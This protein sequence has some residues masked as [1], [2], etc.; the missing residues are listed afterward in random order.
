MIRQHFTLPSYDWHVYVYYAIDCYYAHEII[1]ILKSI[2]CSPS[3]LQKAWGN[4]SSC[5]LDTGLTYSN[6]KNRTSVMVISLSS[7]ADEFQNSFDH[8][9][10]HLAQHII[11]ANDIDPFSEEAQYL[12]GEIGQKMFKVAKKFLCEHCRQKLYN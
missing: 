12:A 10:G 8:E 9:K 11:Q 5:K 7:S 1:S 6:F 4:L 3:D 2:G